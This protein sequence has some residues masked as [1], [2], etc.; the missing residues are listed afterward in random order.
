[1]LFAQLGGRHSLRDTVDGSASQSEKLYHLGCATTSR[2]TLADANNKRP[3]QMYRDLFFK[4]LERTQRIAPQYKLKLPDKLYF[5]DSTT[6][7]LCLHLF[8]WARFRTAKGAVKIHT[9]M[10]ADGLLPTFFIVTEGKVNDTKIAGKL[11]VESG[12]FIVFDRGYHDFNL[13]KHYTDKKIRFV[14]RMKTN[15]RYET[16]TIKKTGK[17]CG[18][19]SDETIRFTGYNTRKK[20]P[21]RLRKITFYDKESDKTLI[22]LSNEFELDANTVAAIYKARWEIELFFKTIKQNLKIK[23]FIGT[24]SN[25]VLTQIYVAMIAYLLVSYYKFNPLC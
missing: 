16:V 1:L 18:V 20:Y 12:S 4:L 11:S 6:I 8:P 3:Y 13:Y 7:D 25:A 9:L 5:M 21:Y 15:A 23:R 22:F 2:S 19:L 14:T 24:S 10:Q 17:K